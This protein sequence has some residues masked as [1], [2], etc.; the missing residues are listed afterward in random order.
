MKR[1]LLEQLAM[2]LYRQHVYAGRAEPGTFKPWSEEDWSVRFA[3]RQ[4]AVELCSEHKD[5][6]GRFEP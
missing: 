3:W 2:E 5:T 4:K 6:F 1:I